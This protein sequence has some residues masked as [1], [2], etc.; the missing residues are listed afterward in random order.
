MGNLIFGNTLKIPKNIQLNVANC[1]S[2]M[3]GMLSQHVRYAIGEK[4][5]DVLDMFGIVAGV[6]RAC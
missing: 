5:G 2:G 4:T 3:T 1:C 6:E